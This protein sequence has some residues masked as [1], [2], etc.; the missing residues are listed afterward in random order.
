MRLL[1]SLAGCV[2]LV[3]V[4]TDTFNTIVLPRR[5]RY[6]FRVTRVFYR[7]TYRPY[8]AIARWIRSGRWR[9]SYLSVYGPLSLL[10]LIGIWAT[11]VILGFGL[12]LWGGGLTANGHSLS[13]FDSVYV[14]ATTF[15]TLGTGD[16]RS[17]R[18]KL[19]T[20]VEGLLGLGFLGLNISY[21]P[22]L[23]QS[24]S[25][26]ELRISLLDARAGSPPSA[27]AFI[28]RQAG[29]EQLLQE[30]MAQ[31]EQWAADLLENHLS[32]PILAYFRSHHENQSWITA[33]VAAVHAA[34]IAVICSQGDLKTQ[35]GLTFAMGRHALVDIAVV[36]RA[37]QTTDSEDRLPS[38]RF[39][40]LRRRLAGT[41]SRLALD[42]L[43]EPELKRIRNLY[44][45]SAVSLSRYF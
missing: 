37:K 43:S 7:S 17:L 21:L 35:A 15:S 29:R 5:T 1:A 2:L 33:L 3:L 16:P 8:S 26:R 19:A 40:D 9:E 38:E 25:R 13:L 42:R 14:S 10:V 4:L 32:Y 44:E 36:F 39:Q 41:P 23:Y 27:S 18:L 34:A 24:F 6:G 11:G 30:Q 31:W 45:P 12:I 28:E 20:M 22:V